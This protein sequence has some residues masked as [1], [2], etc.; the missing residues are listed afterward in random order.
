MKGIQGAFIA[1]ACFQSA[2]GF[3]GLWGNAVRFLSALSVVPYVTFTELGLYHLGFPMLAK[4]VEVGLP[5]II[6]MVFISQYLPRYI[7]SK[8][9]ICD[10]FSILFTVAV[11]W[12]FAQL[13]TSTTV[14][15][16][17][18][19]NTQI[20]CRTDLNWYILCSCKISAT[21]VPPSVIS[22][23]AGGVVGIVSLISNS[24]VSGSRTSSPHCPLK[25]DFAVTL[26]ALINVLFS[27][28]LSVLLSLVIKGIGVLLNGFLGSVAGIT[29]SVENV[30]F[31]AL[32]RVGSRRVIQISAGF[33]IFFSIFA[34]FGAFFASIPLPIVAALYC[35]L[36]SY[37]SPPSWVSQFHSTSENIFMVVEDQLTIQLSD[38]ILVIFMSHTTVAALVA[39]FFDLTLPRENDET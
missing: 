19:E 30:G 12:L 36:F 37:A 11:T 34:K 8:R 3:L 9:L 10:R 13:L 33:M 16:H 39:L 28:Y 20:S 35:V 38:I 32:T 7:Q 6:L 25:C 5:G 14:Y 21:P 24:D 17:K 26:H 22:R 4:C 27:E 31:L 1:A 2:M 29:A 15:K 23:G 18:P